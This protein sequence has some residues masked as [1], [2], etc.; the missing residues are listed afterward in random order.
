MGDETRSSI[1]LLQ[2]TRPKERAVGVGLT[3][4]GRRPYRDLGELV[5]QVPRG[6]HVLNAGRSS[7]GGVL[8][9]HLHNPLKGA[10]E[11]KGHRKKKSQYGGSHG[12]EVY[13][14]TKKF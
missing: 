3:T 12:K 8:G 5:G 11:K 10:Q 1:N 6:V 7:V 13:L 2:G 4:E 9:K 14:T